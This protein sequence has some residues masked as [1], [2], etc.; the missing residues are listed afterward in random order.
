MENESKMKKIL[1]NEVALALG[2]AS[3]VFW[4][5]NYVNSP[6]TKMQL[7]IELMKKDISSIATEHTEYTKN[8]NERDKAIIQM[9]QDIAVIKNTLLEK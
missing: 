5:M 4:L 7:D 6:I 9:Q 2:I 3:T 1:F 8:A